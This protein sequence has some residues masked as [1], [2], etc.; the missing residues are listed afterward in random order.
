MKKQENDID[1]CELKK[2]IYWIFF[3]SEKFAINIE[4]D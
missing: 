2:D 1:K 4:I 3:W